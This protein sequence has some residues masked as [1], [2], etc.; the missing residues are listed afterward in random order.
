M[1]NEDL[2]SVVWFKNSLNIISF[3]TRDDVPVRLSYKIRQ[4]LGHGE[5]QTTT[6]QDLIPVLWFRSLINTK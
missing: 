4:F 3:K 1:I 6:S 2:K 5:P